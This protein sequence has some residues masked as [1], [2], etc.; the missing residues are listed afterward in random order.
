MWPASGI[1]LAGALL[2]GYRIWPGIP[3]GSF[4]INVWTSLD[5]T[6]AESI[7]KSIWLASSI[8]MGASLQAIVGAFLVR[9]F[10]QYPTAFVELQDVIKFLVLGGPVSCLVNST[11]GVTSLLLG[12]VIK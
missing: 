8:G 4:L 6:S 11:S 10:A 2:F 3:L 7:L 1:A 5:T 9:R 12:G